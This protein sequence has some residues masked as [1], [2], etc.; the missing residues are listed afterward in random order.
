MSGL[1]FDNSGNTIASPCH[2]TT[3][4]KDGIFNNGLWYG[5]HFEKGN[6]NYGNWYGGIFNIDVSDEFSSLTIWKN[7]IWND[8]LW[9]NGV[10]KSGM[11]LGGM[12]LNGIFENGFLISEYIG[13]F[14]DDLTQNVVPKVLPPLPVPPS[15]SAPS[16]STVLITG[17][18]YNSCDVKC[19]V[20]NTGGL[21]TIRG[22]CFSVGNVIQQVIYLTFYGSQAGFSA[23]NQGGSG[24]VPLVGS[25]LTNNSFIVDGTTIL[26]FDGSTINL[27]QPSIGSG[28]YYPS[29]TT[30]TKLTS[31]LPTINDF[32][33]YD[34]GTDLGYYTDTIIG[35]NQD[36]TYYVRAFAINS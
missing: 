32:S 8:G 12:W 15:Y 24:V 28:Y 16:V 33:F 9:M 35:L 23:S 13:S 14:T 6:F 20:T 7:G 27:S 10:F 25:V 5:G 34:V 31:N 36:T 21:S 19:N 11:F 22:V 3:H 1:V 26:S 30:Q 18:T 17:I 4:W 29:P 2:H